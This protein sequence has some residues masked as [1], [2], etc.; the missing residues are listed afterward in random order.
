MDKYKEYC[1]IQIILF[2]IEIAVEC[3]ETPF[4]ILLAE[5]RYKM[6]TKRSILDQY[7]DTV[8]PRAKL[9]ANILEN[10]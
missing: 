2:H 1:F 3:W 5:N 6:G 7:L 4:W 10:V 9:F 8:K